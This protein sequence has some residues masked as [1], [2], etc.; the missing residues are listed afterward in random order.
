MNVNEDH[1]N[2]NMQ[3]LFIPNLLDSKGVSHHHLYLADS[4][5]KQ[6]NEKSLQ[7]KKRTASGIFWET[8]GVEELYVDGLT[9][10]RASYVVGKGT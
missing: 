1:P 10:S 5:G 8:F 4:K 6:M 3:W 7:L 2:E 9:G